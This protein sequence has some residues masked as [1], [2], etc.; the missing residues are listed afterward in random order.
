LDEDQELLETMKL[1]IL[2]SFMWREDVVIPLAEKLEITTEDLEQI[3]MNHLDMSSL[4]AIYPRFES[5]RTKYFSEKLH[6]DLRLCLLCDV[7]EII[8]EEEANKIKENLVKEI[9]KGKDY[10]TTLKNGKKQVLNFLK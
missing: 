2:R 6:S 9:S 4:E 7:L 1:R 10:E 3:L 8:P 5:A